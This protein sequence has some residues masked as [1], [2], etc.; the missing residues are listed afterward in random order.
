MYEK[1]LVRSKTNSKI[2]GVCGG[3]GEYFHM[4]PTI[5]RLIWIVLSICPGWV[6]GG[7]IAYIIAAIVI[8]EVDA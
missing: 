2:C 5:V 1:R 4:D 6:M 7:V 3:I 8:P